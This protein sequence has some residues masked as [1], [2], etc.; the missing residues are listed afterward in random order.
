MDELE[1]KDQEGR[2]WFAFFL[3]LGVMGIAAGMV[4]VF[5]SFGQGN[6]LLEIAKSVNFHGH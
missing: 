4:A 6:L 5:L 3:T 2:R 1:L